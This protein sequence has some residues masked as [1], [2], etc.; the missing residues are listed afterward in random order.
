MIG[1]HINDQIETFIIRLEANSGLDGLA[2][3]KNMTTIITDFGKLNIIRP[4][5]TFEKKD[6]K[7]VCKANDINWVEDPTNY[8]FN[9]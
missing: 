6:L 9:L 7:I 5:L 4:L 2:C 8:N 1:H 3:M